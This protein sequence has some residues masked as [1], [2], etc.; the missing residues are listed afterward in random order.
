MLAGDYRFFYVGN[1][2]LKSVCWYLAVFTVKK[3]SEIP[4]FFLQ[5][6]RFFKYLLTRSIKI[7]LEAT[8]VFFRS[9]PSFWYLW[10][11]C[12]FQYH[13]SY[14]LFWWFLVI[15]ALAP[16]SAPF[17]AFGSKRRQIKKCLQVTLGVF[18]CR[19]WIWSQ[20]SNILTP[21]WLKITFLAKKI[22]FLQISHAPLIKIRFEAYSWILLI[23]PVILVFMSPIKF[24]KLKKLFKFLTFF[25]LAPISA[26]FCAF[27]RLW[28]IF[29]ENGK[30]PGGD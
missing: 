11:L 28:R 6:P 27:L 30:T 25:A 29:R 3:P 19:I 10:V 14:K 7:R 9:F 18:L 20:I 15:F 24:S 23:F 17:C 4:V 8:A 22:T 16:I 12:Y 21:S 2:N 26:P 1:P 5:N 13:R